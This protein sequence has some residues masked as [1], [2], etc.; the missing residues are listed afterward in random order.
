MMA[1]TLWR[2]RYSRKICE[3]WSLSLELVLEYLVEDD[4]CGRVVEHTD[5]LFEPEQFRVE[6]RDAVCQVVACPHACEEAAG[7]ECQTVGIDRQA[8]HG[9]DPT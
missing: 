5:E 1:V 9:H 3:P 4:Q 6:V 8:S 7:R 2:E